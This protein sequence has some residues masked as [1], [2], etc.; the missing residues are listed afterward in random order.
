M[1][2]IELIGNGTRAA[3]ALRDAGLCDAFDHHHVVD[4]DDLDVP[5]AL[6]ARARSAVEAGRFPF[7]YGSDCAML[8]SV[9]TDLIEQVGSVG[10]VFVD[11][12]HTRPL[13]DVPPDRLAVLGPEND[14]S[15]SAD[16]QAWLAPL[17]EVADDPT[18]TARRAI[19]HLARSVERWW[20]HIDL[21]VLDPHEFAAQGSGAASGGLT[22][23]QLTDLVTSLFGS[24]THCVGGG[25]AVYDPDQDHEGV[26]ASKIV[27]F[28]RNALSRTT[29]SP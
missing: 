2:D 21:D 23:D 24:R 9:L 1:A 18:G 13:P 22:W 28:I 8:P 5:D 19:E 25:I 20:L 6:I 27:T 15:G 4:N 10:L 3:R 12:A 7:L 26:D 17:A 16:S 11:G 29:I 14:A